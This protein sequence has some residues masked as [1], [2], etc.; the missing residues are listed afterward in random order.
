MRLHWSNRWGSDTRNLAKLDGGDSCR[1]L[2]NIDSF[3]GGKQEMVILVGP[4]K[5]SSVKLFVFAMLCNAF[6]GL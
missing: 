5:L 1:G 2:P 3:D 4:K 6:C